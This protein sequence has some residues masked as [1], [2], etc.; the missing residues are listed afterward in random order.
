MS[1]GV[2]IPVANPYW[3]VVATLQKELKEYRES[4]ALDRARADERKKIIHALRK[5]PG[6]G[7]VRV[8]EEMD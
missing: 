1:D 8:I 7:A 6:K 2:Q 4:P 5:S 3:E